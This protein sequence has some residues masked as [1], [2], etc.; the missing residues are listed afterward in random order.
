M[1]TKFF[2]LT[3]ATLFVVLAIKSYLVADQLVMWLTVACAA[4]SV[5]HALTGKSERITLQKLMGIMLPR[6]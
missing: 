3:M 6:K 2:W 1:T 5:L 4:C